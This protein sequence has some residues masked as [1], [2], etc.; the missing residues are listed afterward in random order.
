MGIKTQI[1]AKFK[2]MADG[3]TLSSEPDG[4]RIHF[5]GNCEKGFDVIF[6][7]IVNNEWQCVAY[8]PLK[9]TWTVYASW[10]SN[11]SWYEG[12]HHFKAT[13]IE[14]KDNGCVKVSARGTIF[15]QK[16][17]FSDIYSIENGLIKIK[18]VWEH[19]EDSYQP[20]ITLV[21]C[22]RVPIQDD[23]Q[24][25]IP[26]IIYNNNP[27]AYP[28]KPVPHIAYAPGAIGLYEEHRLPVPMV[29][30]ES[31]IQNQQFYGSL[32]SIPSRVP[33][34][35]KGSDQWW[36]LGLEWGENYRFSKCFWRC[37]YEWVFKYGLWPS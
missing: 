1:N 20:E 32:L 2:K 35:H 21:N 33:Q 14:E 24:V 26:G 13:K 6:E 36:S 27:N 19:P 17:E 25:L 29:N 5:I 7:K 3:Y 11:T 15:G 8:F 9:Q 18:R 10:N 28:T 34:G 31:T 4:L 30:V 16:W 23:P 37:S 22:V 12:A